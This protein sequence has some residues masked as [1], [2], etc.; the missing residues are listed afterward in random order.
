MILSFLLFVIF[1]GFCIYIAEEHTRHVSM[2]FTVAVE[3]VLP[4]NKHTL[5]PPPP[6]RQQRRTPHRQQYDVAHNTLDSRPQSSP[7]P[8]LHLLPLHTSTLPSTPPTGPLLSPDQPC[9]FIRFHTLTCAQLLLPSFSPCLQPPLSA[10]VAALSSC[11]LFALL[12]LWVSVL[13]CF[14]SLKFVFFL[15]LGF[16]IFI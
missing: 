14:F 10:P 2:C 5:T 1:L 12:L 16:N 15:F 6:G 13:R 3:C 4:Y 8:A 7:F 9:I 11:F